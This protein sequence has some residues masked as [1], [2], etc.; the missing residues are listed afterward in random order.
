MANPFVH[1]HVHSEYSLLDG[2][3]KTDKLISRAKEL[4][5]PA[6]A[7]TDHGVMY[8]A[9]EF[10][11]GCKKAEI[12]PLVGM[13]GYVVKDHLK[14]EGKAENFHQLLL[15]KNHQG[16]QNLMKLATLAHLDGFYY[17]PRFSKELLAK[18]SE[19][20]ICTSACPKGELGQL[21]VNGNDQAAKK[22]IEWYQE[23]FGED[24]YLEIQ[25]HQFKDYLAVA[26]EAKVTQKLKDL[27]LSED[28]W[29]KG[30]IKLSRDMGVKLLATNDSHYVNQTDA[31]AQDALVCIST[32]KNVADIERL[33]Y[34]DAPTF[35]L[36]T[37][38]EM[39][40][41]F[42]D[43]PD[44][45]T[46]TAE[47][48]A[49]CDL[50]IELG[51]WY[52][53]HI[54]LPEGK[55][56]GEILQEMAHTKLNQ[57]YAEV[58]DELKT[59]L[60]FELDIIISKGYAPYF[61]MM[62]DMVNWCSDQGII[63]N[64]RGS[65]AGSLVSYVTGITTVDPIKYELPFE[66]F[67]NPFR[68]LP[69]DIDLDIADDRREDLL[70]YI[71]SKY[72]QD[73]VAQICTFGRMLAR[74]SVRDIG[75][76]L[77]H[78]YSYPDKIA[79]LIPL[80]NQGFP[81]SIAKALGASPELKIMYDTDPSAKHLL[82]LAQEI[83]GN[84]R[85]ISV[86]AAGVVVSPTAM[87]DFAPLQNEPN[88]DKV[89]TQYEF[90]A[91]EDIGLVKFDILGIRNLAILG[92]ARD[93]VEAAR[94]VK[95]N[96]AKLPLD[97]KKTFNMLAR[98]ETMGVFQLGGSGMTK[99]LKELKP[100]RL[101]DI[102]IMIALFRPGPMANIPEYIARKNKKSTVKYMFPKME[103]YLDKS[104]GIL[105]YQEDIMFTAIEIAGYS[106]KTVD[107]LRKAIG[108]KLPK[109]M[110]QQHEI[111][112]KGCQEH[113][114]LSKEEAEQLWE[115]FVPFQGYGFNKAHAASYGVVSYQTAY[116][117]AHYPV[118]Y[119]TALLTAESG[120]TEK[121]VEAIEECRRMKIVVLA[122]DINK[123]QSSFTVEL[124]DSSLDSRAIR[125]GLSA[126]KNVGEVAIEVVLKARNSEF[127]SF[128]DFCLRV[129]AQKVN[130]KVLE[131]LIKSG[132][133]DGFGK[134]SAQLAALDR[135]RELG[136]SVSKLKSMGQTALFAPEESEHTDQL[137]DI[138]EFEKGQK[139]VMEKELLGFYLTEHPH[140]DKLAQL[141]QL[142][143]HRISEL[144][145]GNLS[146]MKVTV[147]GIVETVRNVT[148]KNSNQPMCFAKIVDS[149]KSIEAVVFPK[150]Y[151]ASASI[152]Q[153]DKVVIISGKVEMREVAQEE[154][155]NKSEADITVIV[156]SAVE[157]TGPDTQL[158]QPVGRNFHEPP[159][160]KLQP[161][162]TIEVPA[163]LPSAKLVSLN[164][165]LTEHK[166]KTPA[167]LEFLK[168][169]TSKILPLPYGLNWS[170][171]LE[172]QIQ[173]LL[174][175]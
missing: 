103:K 2:L 83:E 29:V 102:M 19:G 131:S 138:D 37:E 76:V 82:D 169:G 55:S 161:A 70:A 126:I 86:H 151:A 163:G 145:S 36:R 93:L 113:S 85:H 149:G 65:A 134:R 32:G 60:D 74:A 84:A 147:G 77:G 109:E 66:R 95:I 68:P 114:H 122:P 61:L 154:E 1:L 58:N 6:V 78:P 143:T 148:T 116:L 18:Y 111:F 104:F 99:W 119:M 155:E 136:T 105:V 98:G 150:V 8:G 3:S 49:K 175:S 94:E 165:L 162:I 26:T 20:L 35:H 127:K 173:A 128:T 10:Y 137:P 115:L 172:Q 75:R 100:T 89:I 107:A 152:W 48:A 57:R 9:I 156:D 51:Q 106:W 90:H 62:A 69:P 21:L 123:S 91:C 5:M 50:Q 56:A 146:G 118:E 22:L 30:I 47:V 23:I 132:A 52:F 67:L 33:R 7:L 25:R 101:E 45:L 73:K 39:S 135:I 130:K 15:A 117:K 139:L 81:M 164:G 174:K 34:I 80:G 24:Y 157:F 44:A 17:R 170:E 40:Q 121:V 87:T 144:P 110:A 153:V 167:N 43:V 141:G 133:M 97:D 72:G 92:A 11:K 171:E 4:G 27:Q 16:Y 160:I 158:P 120:D 88:G 140:A 41:I 63:T 53:P 71:V 28:E 96:L 108:K 79:K 59:R 124:N 125:F 129:D 42:A 31:T 12:K 166:G 54:D 159:P 64:T 142:V 38:E 112:V 46:N 13:E 168:N 14:K